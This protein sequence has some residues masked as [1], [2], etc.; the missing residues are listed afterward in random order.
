MY[1]IALHLYQSM[2][3]SRISAV[4]WFREIILLV[5]LKYILFSLNLKWYRIKN[6]L[7]VN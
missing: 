5:R 7:T 6:L 4:L 1:D 3:L 2:F